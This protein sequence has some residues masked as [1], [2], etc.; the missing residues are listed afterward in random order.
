MQAS[1]RTRCVDADV[2]CII[3][4]GHPLNIIRPYT[5][6]HIWASAIKCMN[7]IVIIGAVGGIV[8]N[9]PYIRISSTADLPWYSGKRSIIIVM[10]I[11]NSSWSCR[12]DADIT[13]ALIYKENRWTCR[14]LYI[15]G[16]VHLKF[17]GWIHL[18]DADVA[19]SFKG[20]SVRT[21][22]EYQIIT[23]S[24]HLDIPIIS[25][26]SYLQTCGLAWIIRLN[27]HNC[28]LITC[29]ACICMYHFTR[30]FRPNSYLVADKEI[31]SRI[32]YTSSPRPQC[33][34]IRYWIYLA[35]L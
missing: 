26:R 22:I 9:T 3:K 7:A 34:A 19:A 16:T 10:N 32:A 18:P 13:V 6:R 35:M 31:L 28:I 24:S 4:Y 23:C 29:W 17:V 15:Q 2:A 20:Y 27:A 5:Y 21:V 12:P 1:N 8:K 11:K 25:T 30:T 33:P 14:I